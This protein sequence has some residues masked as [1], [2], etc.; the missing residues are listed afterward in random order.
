M[1]DFRARQ[2]V[3][4]HDGTSEFGFATGTPLFVTI[5][6]GGNS[7]TVDGSVS[8]SS[9]GGTVTI[10]DGGNSITVDGTVAVSAISSTV[11]VDIQD[12]WAGVTGSGTESGALRVT[13]ATDSTGVLSVDDNGSTLSID[14]GDGSIT[15]DG[16]VTV[17]G[18]VTIQDGGNSITVD[19]SDL[20]IRNLSASQDSVKIGDG[21]DFLAVNGDGSIN[22]VIAGTTGT[23]IH[24]YDTT[25]ALAKD[26]TDDHDYTVTGGK[27]LLVKQVIVA[28]SGAMKVT[29]QAGP[30]ASLVTYAVIFTS[31][32]K[33]TEVITFEEPISVPSTSTGT[34]RVTR[35]NDDSQAMD[36]YSTIIGVES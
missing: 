14:D 30:L 36:V 4:L 17:S 27:T 16:S 11:N 6:D 33:P 18:T 2:R 3:A 8:V 5:Q 12:S 13:I 32:A 20:D 21:T 35:R 10:Q 29:I 34:V 28:A 25:S 26:G 19:A 15:V 7:I 23:R 31:G 9:V 22:V 24:S 1:A